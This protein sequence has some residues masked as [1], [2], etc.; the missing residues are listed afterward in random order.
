[1]DA[2][3]AILALFTKLLKRMSRRGRIPAKGLKA[4][5]FN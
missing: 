3:E 2:A 5:I 4:H 1:M